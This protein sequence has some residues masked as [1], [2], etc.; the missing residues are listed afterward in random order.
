MSM[1]PIPSSSRSHSLIR[2]RMVLLAQAQR[3][4]LAEIASDITRHK[5][6]IARLEQEGRALEDSLSRV[7]YPVLTLPNEITARIFVHCL[8]S[9]GERPSPQTAP[10]L[11]AQICRHWRAV[12]L[13]TCELWSQLYI[14]WP[15]YADGTASSAL[16]RT[17]ISHAKGRPLSLGLD[18][19][20]SQVPLELLEF[21]SSY[22]GQIRRLEIC[23]SPAQFHHLCPPHTHSPL[24]QYFTTRLP[25]DEDLRAF[26]ES[27]PSL[28]ELS[29]LGPAPKITFR[30]PSLMRLKIRGRIVGDVPPHPQRL[31]A[32]RG[33][34]MCP[35]ESN[36]LDPRCPYPRNLHIPVLLDPP[37]DL[38]V[39]NSVRFPSLCRLG[40]HDIFYRGEPDSLEIV[41]SFISRSSCVISHLVLGLYVC[42]EE[43]F[44]DWLE[45]FP[46]LKALEIQT[47]L[48]LDYL[49]PCLS[50]ASVSPELRDL[51]IRSLESNVDY[52][53]LIEMLQQRRHPMNAV[54]LQSFHLDLC[55]FREE[56]EPP[57]SW[58]PPNLAASE[59]KR[60]MVDG[61]RF[62]LI[63]SPS[64]VEAESWPDPSVARKSG[65]H[66]DTL[67]S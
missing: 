36:P 35:R 9:H 23:L 50:A 46:S 59:L 10:L 19:N 57:H 66:F 1:D 27:A 3:D 17:W 28:R 21:I 42:N 16:V 22:C 32:S 5:T 7:V 60:M 67:H 49:I 53:V 39:L 24:L 26:L 30:L 56:D 47:D 38:S 2:Q 33:A 65:S 12:A 44:A 54:K 51:K 31:T 52:N 25:V 62:V 37:G 45:A 63:L 58:P 64:G 34:G 6:H 18:A 20:R 43:E 13:A 29:F 61:L 11:P 40:L 41:M 48:D 4:R 8:P 55:D 15:C 14:R